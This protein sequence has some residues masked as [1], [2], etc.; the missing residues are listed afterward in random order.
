M[1]SSFTL[2]QGDV[3]G[4]MAPSSYVESSDIEASQKTLEALGY[5]VRVHDQTFA[6]DGQLAGTDA[7]K[8]EAFH[9]LY[10]DER[11]TA[12][13]AAGG[14][15]GALS[16]INH[17]DYNLIKANPK[18]LIGFSDTTA[19]INAISV[20]TDV[21]NFHGPVFKN[22]YKTDD[23]EQRLEILTGRNDTLSLEGAETI[24]EGEASGR[25]LG[26]NLS[27]VQ[28]LPALLG[29]DAFDGAILFIEDCGEE[30]SRL[31]RTLIYLKT[32]GIAEKLS[33]IIF[34]EFTNLQDTGRPYGFNLLQLIRKFSA[35]L[36]IPV[37]ANAPF[38]HEKNLPF[39][40]VGKTVE[41][42][43]KAKQIKL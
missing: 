42:C 43:A 29:G 30:L 26:G 2:N 23:L 24:H 20:R 9:A 11:V 1:S 5:N 21:V 41:F 8:L 32:L 14:G 19:L 3:I 10:E 6:R 7:E 15:N 39:F 27:I 34:G 40:P 37:L 38:G 35:E 18:P 16:L 33:G 25:L 12:I 13:W 28:Y 4:V 31:D 36:D 17:L 22:L